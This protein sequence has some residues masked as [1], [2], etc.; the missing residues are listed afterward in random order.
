MMTF[1]HKQI[2]LKGVLDKDIHEHIGQRIFFHDRLIER[3]I[4]DIDL[5]VVSDNFSTMNSLLH[6]S[7]CKQYIKQNIFIVY[8]NI[9]WKYENGEERMVVYVYDGDYL[10][11]TFRKQLIRMSDSLEPN[12]YS[13]R[14]R[15]HHVQDHQLTVKRVS[16]HFSML[17]SLHDPNIK[18]DYICSV[19]GVIVNRQIQRKH[20]A[21]S[22]KDTSYSL[23]SFFMA[24]FC[25]FFGDKMTFNYQP[26]ECVEQ[27]EG[28]GRSEYDSRFS[29]CSDGHVRQAI[30]YESC[31]KEDFNVNYRD[32]ELGNVYK[33]PIKTGFVDLSSELNGHYP[34]VK[35][36]Y[37]E[38]VV[39]DENFNGFLYE[40]RGVKHLYQEHHDC[41]GLFCDKFCKEHLDGGNHKMNDVFQLENEE[42]VCVDSPVNYDKLHQMHV[43]RNSIDK[44]LKK[45]A[46]ST[47]IPT[48]RV[49]GSNRRVRVYVT[50]INAD[51][52]CDFLSPHTIQ[53]SAF[54][55][56]DE[57]SL[58]VRLGEPL[59]NIDDHKHV[60]QKWQRQAL[61]ES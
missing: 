23:F 31:M 8:D 54:V 37:M 28:V 14:V 58:Q 3:W 27:L 1:V 43:E 19:R 21:K 33:S 41:D 18:F 6:A 2:G 7:H 52:S 48:P 55:N 30:S 34:G 50:E 35:G 12:H 4:R 13:I 39:Y 46:Q 25:Q 53:D 47:L 22:Y 42:M 10:N 61:L 15:D 56:Y 45:F 11:V 5:D 17:D 26:I 49:N 51:L 60:R 9:T 36:H 24:L 44:N 40:D 32:C 20:K 29:V 16:R 59:V 57:D 38:H